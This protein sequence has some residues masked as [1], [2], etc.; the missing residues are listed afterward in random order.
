MEYE[1]YIYDLISSN[2]PLEYYQMVW[3]RVAAQELWEELDWENLL[4]TWMAVASDGYEG[5]GI[6][7]NLQTIL[8]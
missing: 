4:K 1:R 5:F 6:M 3:S 7:A 8:K 2:Q